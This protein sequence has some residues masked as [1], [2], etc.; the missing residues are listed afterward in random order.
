MTLWGDQLYPQWPSPTHSGEVLGTRR[1]GA[2]LI[3][4][5]QDAVLAV[6]GEGGGVTR[7]RDS[8][9]GPAGVRHDSLG[10]GYPSGGQHYSLAR[11]AAQKAGLVHAALRWRGAHDYLD[12]VLRFV[13]HGI[14][15]GEPVLVAVP[16]DRVDQVRTALGP[17]ADAVQFADMTAVGRNPG[18]ILAGVLCPFVDKHPNG[19]VRVVT[20]PVWPGR[21]EA[22]YPGCVQHEALINLALAH[23]PATVLCAYDA[24]LAPSVLADA[25]STHPI[26][27]E[28]GEW[29]ASPG[30]A[31]PAEVVDAW[32]QSLPE[33]REVPS[34]LV[35][36]A[37]GGPRQVR[38]VTH[39]VAERA[40]LTGRRLTDLLLA[41]NE[42]A[43]NTVL[44]TGRPGL[45]SIWSDADQVVCQVHDSGHIADPLAGRR[46]PA[47]HD[48]AG[49]GLRLVHDLC[50]LVR[51]HTRPGETTVR[52][53]M[54][55]G[56]D[57]APAPQGTQRA[58]EAGPGQPDSSSPA[59]AF[60]AG[61]PARAPGDKPTARDLLPGAPEGEQRQR[62]ARCFGGGQTTPPR[63]RSRPGSSVI[64]AVRQQAAYAEE[65]ASYEA[66]SAVFH[67]WRRR[68][69]ERLPLRPGDVVLD[70][71]CG[72]GVCFPL[73]RQRI[74]TSGTIVGIDASAAMLALARERVADRGWNNVVLIEAAA[75][76]A[77]I[78][79][80]ADHALF[81]TVHDV[82]QS[83]R[84]LRNVLARVRPRGSVAAVGG[85]W[86][87]PWAIGLNAL[88]ATTHTPL[89]RSFTG[90]DRPWTLLG[91][92][93]PH[94]QVR[95]IDMGCGYL[96]IGQTSAR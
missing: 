55:L 70:V 41:V 22:E 91:E 84:A 90:F 64:S 92:H 20:E 48:T 78:S 66:R 13:G 96:A 16:G 19:R 71:G 4:G 85:K 7:S 60:S 86:A 6:E 69:V 77:V 10:H 38:R 95:E 74:G 80:V 12:G 37:P 32:N 72:T 8:R 9:R 93:L 14:G 54:R 44:H 27:L 1:G 87:P 61:N 25:E 94:L 50:D 79:T 24:R 28:H 53:H 15:I 65:A 63:P 59:T 89:V 45:F 88:V 75:E 43:T 5:P 68:V 49:H 21:S 42:V 18:R 67:H 39:D 29:R 83:P 62:P 73:L 36:A 52:M 58:V 3:D 82:L 33:P 11:G 56:P 23:R 35:F 2:G 47:P 17:T 30:F 46:C 81:C 31:D 26:L 57:H 76:N 34:T 40:G 51:V